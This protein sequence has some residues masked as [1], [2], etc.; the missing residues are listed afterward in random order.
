MLFSSTNLA[1]EEAKTDFGAVN[2]P[3]IVLHID[4][5]LLPAA[6][7]V[8]RKGRVPFY[9][10]DGLQIFMGHFLQPDIMLVKR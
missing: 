6:D 5:A 10:L 7:R 4:A 3:S 9:V 8:V 1:L 2:H